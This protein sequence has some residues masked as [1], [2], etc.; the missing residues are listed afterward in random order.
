MTY[1]NAFAGNNVHN[2]NGLKRKFVRH[3]E[4]ISIKNNDNENITHTDFAGQK[5]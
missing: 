2:A 3:K 1:C 5:A 4:H